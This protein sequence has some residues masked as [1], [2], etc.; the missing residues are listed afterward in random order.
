MHITHKLIVDCS[1]M[2]Y[3]DFAD[4]CLVALGHSPD[5]KLKADLPTDTV[6]GSVSIIHYDGYCEVTVECY[7]EHEEPTAVMSYGTISGRESTLAV[8]TNIPTEAE[9]ISRLETLKGAT[10]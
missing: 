10:V 7:H 6:H 3:A 8:A 1:N 2:T 5:F 4:K 9:L